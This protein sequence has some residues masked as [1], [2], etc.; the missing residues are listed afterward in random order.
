M[1]ARKNIRFAGLLFWVASFLTSLFAGE[2]FDH[3]WGPFYGEYE[4]VYGNQRVKYLGPIGDHKTD[5]TGD[6]IRAVRP[7]YHMGYQAEGDFRRSEFLWPIGVRRT[8]DDSSYTR[9][10]LNF[11]WNWDVKD[12]SSAWRMWLLP[13]YFQGRAHDGE[14]YAALFPI[15][16]NLH[17]FFFW[18]RIDFTLWPLWVESWKNDVHA[19]TA[20]WPLFS[21]TTGDGIDRFRMFP[22][23]GYSESEGL[24]RK[25]FVLWPFF[26]FVRY[27]IP[28]SSGTGWILFPL[29]GHL[30]LT[31]QETWWLLP[32][33][34]RY[35]QGEQQ[36]RLFGPWPIFQKEE[37]E[38]DKFY[39]LPFYGRKSHAGV[40]K[41]LFLWP[42]GQAERS[43][44]VLGTKEKFRFFPF[45]QSFKEQPAPEYPTEKGRTHYLKVWPLFQR[46][47]EQEETVQELRVFDFNPM[48]GGPVDRNY[49]PFWQIYSRSQVED[50]VDTE[51]LWG[52][53]RSSKRGEDYRY[54]SLFPL[55]SWSR[56]QEGG[57][58]SLLKGLLSRKKNGEDIQWRL[59][60]LFKFGDSGESQ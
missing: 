51:F 8:R 54:R 13:F 15:Y 38:V 19:K 44:R 46:Y 4:D 29:T 10:L 42:L 57:H 12:P 16:G 28:E 43:E 39:L 21:K 14:S 9:V 58:F 1:S 36:S 32:P 49:A 11:F 48:R 47:T 17:E 18:D 56:E 41:W 23:Y 60:Y 52:L 30:K 2:V 53:Y 50:A 40:D 27:D 55:F 3:D 33:I 37:G 7:F 31:D 6:L 34:F 25:T 35:T 20:F 22:F 5:A 59:L 45:V 24:G 26:T